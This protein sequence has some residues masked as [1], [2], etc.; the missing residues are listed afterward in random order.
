MTAQIHKIEPAEPDDSTLL[1][2]IAQRDQAAAR[3]FIARHSDY[4]MK[5]AMLKLQNQ[6]EAEDITQDVF[7]AVWRTAE[8]WREGDAK[9][10]SWLYRITYNR[11]IDILRKRRPTQDI[12]VAEHIAD[13]ADSAEN[14]QEQADQYRLIRDALDKLNSKQKRAIEL[15]YFEDM[16]QQEAADLMDMSLAA[17]ESQLRRARAQLHK[18]LAQNRDLLIAL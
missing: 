14:L 3:L 18:Y 16:K 15:I 2:R 13:N 7:T 10:T 17:F 4:I 6:A 5:I 8:K 9:V 1:Y 11:C 12:S